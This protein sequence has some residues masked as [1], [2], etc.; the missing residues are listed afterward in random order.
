MDDVLWGLL[1]ERIGYFLDAADRAAAS[2]WSGGPLETRRLVAAWRALL[3]Q[4]RPARRG[5][6][7][8]CGRRGGGMCGVWRVASAYFVHR[9]PLTPATNTIPESGGS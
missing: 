4:H 5:G 3:R 7:L 2:Q 1:R 8:G 6:C 9:L